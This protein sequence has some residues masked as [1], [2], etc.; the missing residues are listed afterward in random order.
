MFA[1]FAWVLAIWIVL[2]TYA[3]L[4]Y[5]LRGNPKALLISAGA[6]VVVSLVVA[7]LIAKL[8]IGHSF[9]D[10]L[11]TLAVVGSVFIFL[12]EKKNFSK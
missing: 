11:F 10:S 2:Q 8:D 9:Y 3:S 12:R 1:F 7:L 5:A 4:R 6:F